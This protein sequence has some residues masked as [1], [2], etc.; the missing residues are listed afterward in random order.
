MFPLQ[1]RLLLP[2]FLL[3]LPH[4]H[5]TRSH[6][7]RVPSLAGT[8]P[9]ASPAVPAQQNN[10]PLRGFATAT[11][12]QLLLPNNEGNKVWSCAGAWLPPAG[13]QGRSRAEKPDLQAGPGRA[14]RRLASLT[15]FSLPLEERKQ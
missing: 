6:P 7:P 1:L 12:P 14:G 9:A 4:L 8:G 11:K 10:R 5:P 3:T 2:L 13:L 15:H